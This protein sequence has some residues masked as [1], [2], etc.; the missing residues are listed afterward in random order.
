METALDS[1]DDDDDNEQACLAPDC[2]TTHS[3][4]C[5]SAVS[6][7]DCCTVWYVAV[8]RTSVGGAVV[9]RKWHSV[10]TVRRTE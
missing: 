2:G 9:G 6:S 4:Y 1:D 5:T 3:L 10:L 8:V 7:N